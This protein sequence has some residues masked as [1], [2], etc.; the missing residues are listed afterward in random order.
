M[1]VYNTINIPDLTK[2]TK[3]INEHGQY[4]PEKY[5][6]LILKFE[7]NEDYKKTEQRI[8]NY[9]GK[10]E[11]L[12]FNQ[13]IPFENTLYDP[14][15]GLN[16]DYTLNEDFQNFLTS[17][18]FVSTI[19]YMM[20]DQASNS[21]NNLIIDEK[22]RKPVIFFHLENMNMTNM[23]DE[24]KKIIKEKDELYCNQDKNKLINYYSNIIR[25]TENLK[26]YYKKNFLDPNKFYTDE[27][28]NIIFR[29]D[30]DLALKFGT[31]T[32]KTKNIEQLES[33]GEEQRVYINCLN[34]DL[35]KYQ[36][37][38]Y[39]KSENR[40]QNNGFLLIKFK[41]E[42]HV[43]LYVFDCKNEYLYSMNSAVPKDD[44]M[45]HFSLTE[46]INFFLNENINYID[47]FQ[48]VPC[49]KFSFQEQTN[50]CQTWTLYLSLILILN[51]KYIDK[52]GE[53]LI[54]LKN[55]DIYRHF[56]ILQFLYYIYKNNIV[57]KND[58]N[59]ITNEE[60]VSN[61]TYLFLKYSKPK[62]LSKSN[63]KETLK[64]KKSTKKKIGKRK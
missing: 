33:L 44:D 9:M 52:V 37:K 43:A 16:D 24:I 62:N 21:V 28:F 1:S 32:Y 10:S 3:L 61:I 6:K 30:V 23:E 11:I 34:G 4:P 59:H 29:A 49:E 58:S 42:M 57:K 38:I 20:S 41:F 45:I 64:Q 25:K 40:N 8:L 7:E 26:E 14:K 18:Q 17:E 60:I 48:H 15:F 51:P 13:E 55:I 12:K 5:D 46:T 31:F 27:E 50:F 53:L 47:I 22:K 56:F 63:S 39:C 2:L 36:K 35:L 54:T 19:Y